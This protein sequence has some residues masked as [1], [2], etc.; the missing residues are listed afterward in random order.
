MGIC[1]NSLRKVI[2]L[3]TTSPCSLKKSNSF[4][5][6]RKGILLISEPK[7]FKKNLPWDFSP[8]L[9]GHVGGLG[10]AVKMEENWGLECEGVAKS[11]EKKSKFG[12]GTPVLSEI[13]TFPHPISLPPLIL[14]L[15]FFPFFGLYS[16]TETTNVTIRTRTKIPG[17]G[18]SFWQIIA[19]KWR[20]LH[21]WT[22]TIFSAPV[23]RFRNFFC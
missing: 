18:G 15:N 4:N 2:G 14:K 9:C 19:P 13:R 17:E 6:I 8:G 21:K 20:P 10:L 16:Q 1:F 23:G 3:I 22:W 7:F 11:D 12:P 5:P